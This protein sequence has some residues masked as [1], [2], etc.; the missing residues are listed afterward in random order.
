MQDLRITIIQSD[1]F[2]E[3]KEKN[4]N[5]FQTKL[6]GIKNSDIIIL[7]EMFNT[8]FS[9]KPE[10]FAETMKDG[11][12]GWMKETAHRKQS[13][14]VGSLMIKE[15][16]NYY[17]RLMWVN[18]DGSF[19]YYDKRHL[20]RMGNEQE[21][22]S[23]GQR[24]KIVDFMGWKFKLLVCYDLRFPVWAKNNYKNGNYDFDC[25][26]YVANWPAARTHHW[27]ALLKARAIENQSYVIGVN[28]IGEDGKGTKHCGDSMI[29]DP[30]GDSLL[31]FPENTEASETINLSY[32]ELQN[33]RNKFTVGLDWDDFEIEKM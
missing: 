30:K 18:P 5:S 10:L 20:F 24:N 15:N 33:L 8:A 31:E 25:L 23:A 7:P 11:T 2:W 17:N 21:H 14:V 4:I 12:I 13:V 27:K 19:D 28:R 16:E 29:F 32:S 9:M 3:N 6:Q 22:F 1:L 26:I